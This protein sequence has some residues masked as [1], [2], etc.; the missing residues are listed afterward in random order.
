MYF[1]KFRDVMLFN[2]AKNHVS[3]AHVCV[4]ACVCVRVYV[5]VRARSLVK[6]SSVRSELFGIFKIY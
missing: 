6:L 2:N 3:R 5:C 1:K 4:R